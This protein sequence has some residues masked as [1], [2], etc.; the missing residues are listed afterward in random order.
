TFTC[1]ERNVFFNETLQFRIPSTLVLSGNTLQVSY[2]GFESINNLPCGIG[3]ITD[4]TSRQY[5][6]GENG[7]FQLTGFTSDPSGT[8]EM[9]INIAASVVGFPGEQPT[10]TSLINF[11]YFLRVRNTGAACP[12]IDTTNTLTSSCSNLS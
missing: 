5:N 3:W 9:Q 4:R 6:G 12:N 2:V 1:E 7:C 11:P 10:N 8:Y